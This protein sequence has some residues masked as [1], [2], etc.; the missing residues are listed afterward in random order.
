M[1]SDH[2]TKALEHARIVEFHKF[3][4]EYH[5]WLQ[6]GSERFRLKIRIY[7]TND[8]RF[9][10]VQ[11]HFIQTPLTDSGGSPTVLTLETPHSALSTAV[12]SITTFYEDAV[13]K[14]HEPNAGWFVLNDSF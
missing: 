8:G 11:S 7:E 5:L 9:F 13:S 1:L 3:F 2:E 12:E 4:S 14:G 6:A 10:F